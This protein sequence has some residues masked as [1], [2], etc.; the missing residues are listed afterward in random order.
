MRRTM[1]VIGFVMFVTQLFL[2]T[3]GVNSVI[4]VG[5][6]ALCL[7]L[8]SALIP[9][10][11]RETV[12]IC[13]LITVLAGCVTFW[14]AYTFRYQP[15]TQYVGQR[16]EIYAHA[17][18]L[19]TDSEYGEQ[20]E[21]RIASIDG[22]PADCRMML[23]SD[24]L[25]DAE[26]S[27]G[28]VFTTN[29]RMEPLESSTRT[30]LLGSCRGERI[31]VLSE[32]RSFSGVMLS[33]RRYTGNTLRRL[34]PGSIGEMLAGLL[35]GDTSA[36]SQDV[37]S[38]LRGSGV[39]HLFAVSGFHLSVFS[40]A[41]LRIFSR[42]R[43][44]PRIVSVAAACI[45]LF[46]MAMTGFSYSCVRAGI[47]I[48]LIL[49]GFL[50]HRQADS[51]NS[52]GFA[53][54]F[55]CAID[56][57]SASDSGLQ[58]SV[59]GVLCMIYVSPI[60]QKC[61]RFIHFRPKRIAR[62]VRRF[63][64]V[65]LLSASIQ[66]AT[67]PVTVIAFRQFSLSAPI[68]NALVLPAAHSAMLFAAAAV[69]T[70]WSGFF[71]PLFRFCGL[72]AGLLAKFSLAVCGVF[73]RFSLS[74]DSMQMRLI[75]IWIAGTLLI[76]AI[77]VWIPMTV[78]RRATMLSGVSV[79]VLAVC[80]AFGAWMNA[81]TATITLPDVGNASAI[82]LQSKGERALLG[83]GDENAPRKIAA[84][85]ADFDT[86]FVPRFSRTEWD[87]FPKVICTV[88]VRSV[89]VPDGCFLR[90]PRSDSFDMTISDAGSWRTGAFDVSYIC[91]D[92]SSAA[93]AAV[94]GVS[95]LF[96]F[97]ADKVPMTMPASWKCADVVC[98]RGGLPHGWEAEKI[99]LILL[100]ASPERAA[101]FSSRVRQNGGFI[102]CTFEEGDLCLRISSDGLLRLERGS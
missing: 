45:V 81:G 97:G 24:K 51:L 18:D 3:F 61:V 67:L 88:P 59:I 26:L 53:L 8:V 33:I 77:S 32:R 55:L 14:W 16:V 102:A 63:L 56:A 68:A 41:L 7:F 34:L 79:S 40:M 84:S 60:T 57:F 50:M 86:L 36:L 98:T 62:M 47:M 66:I 27:D 75:C 31:L 72:C 1:A 71:L 29:L 43:L 30:W 94:N 37:A 74:F 101:A 73:G 12:L 83:C 78:R 85:A 5:V 46:I 54:T 28:F 58:L 82:I 42:K 65:L 22:E 80:I 95:V 21:L 20:I 89:I 35:T 49:L 17:S 6:T 23:Y 70:S 38:S 13:S 39:M 4:P 87:G 64:S 91:A 25:P 69:L 2:C 76:C 11:R 52:L 10:L 44:P 48:L 90:P 92:D 96:L 93:Y 15:L 9:K 19:P 100:S 99:G